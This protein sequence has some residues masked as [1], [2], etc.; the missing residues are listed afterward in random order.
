MIKKKSDLKDE[1]GENLANYIDP[2]HV[3][4]LFM[5]FCYQKRVVH[6]SIFLR[7]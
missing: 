2:K 3:G 7:V 4:E 1:F 5:G 6:L